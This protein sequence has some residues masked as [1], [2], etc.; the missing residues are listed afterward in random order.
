MPMNPMV[1]TPMKADSTINN[2][3]YSVESTE[4]PFYKSQQSSNMLNV[5]GFST[6]SSP[7]SS[8][9][10]P[11]PSESHFQSSLLY[12]NPM[13]DLSAD[14][15]LNSTSQT[16]LLMRTEPISPM[17]QAKSV[18]YDPVS[19]ISPTMIQQEV[20]IGIHSQLQPQP[21]PQFQSQSQQNLLSPFPLPSL[22]RTNSRRQRS[23][24]NLKTGSSKPHLPQVQVIADPITGSPALCRDNIF[25]SYHNST[26]PARYYLTISRL[27]A[28]QA[29]TMEDILDEVMRSFPSTSSSHPSKI[30]RSG[31]L[32]EC[33]TRYKKAV[34]EAQLQWEDEKQP[35]QTQ[36]KKNHFETDSGA[37][38]VT[39]S[40]EQ[41]EKVEHMEQSRNSMRA[42][43]PIETPTLTDSRET[44]MIPYYFSVLDPGHQNCIIRPDMNSTLTICGLLNQLPYMSNLNMFQFAV[45]ALP[46]HPALTLAHPKDASHPIHTS[47]GV[48]FH[49]PSTPVV[50]MG[51]N[52]TIMN[53]QGIYPGPTLYPS[54][55]QLPVFC[56]IP[57]KMTHPSHSLSLQQEVGLP[58]SI[59][60]NLN[61]FPTIPRY[62]NLL[63][64]DF[65]RLILQLPNSVTFFDPSEMSSS[66]KK[67]GKALEDGMTQSTID[68]LSSTFYMENL[69]QVLGSFHQSPLISKMINDEVQKDLR[70][71]YQMQTQAAESQAQAQTQ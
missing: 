54:S 38:F 26:Y 60:V 51:S 30:S 3:F 13:L 20:E 31:A 37:G 29:S 70:R 48:L 57:P 62:P 41:I 49:L 65:I 4:N 40:R 52:D 42:I 53:S 58:H 6:I 69:S 18:R 23:D 27:A 63:N 16:L 17:K 47:Q 8:T 25:L 50:T 9:C 44:T 2:D 15:T 14:S 46:N 1:T 64:E 67:T 19:Y 35:R 71:Q 33:I 56:E 34:H 59:S 5:P 61:T 28:T 55:S 43:L 21:Q 39:V 10:P 36:P 32:S 7:T 68:Q 24:R 66:L 12:S 22:S 45:S 11:S